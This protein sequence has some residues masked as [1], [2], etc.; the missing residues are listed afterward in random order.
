MAD[1][2]VRRTSSSVTDQ[3][4]GDLVSVAARDISQL[5]RY[6]LD[7][8]KLEL[9]ADAKRLGIGG[10]AAG[11]R[12]LRSLPGPDAALLRLRLRAGNARH[13]GVG[14]VPDR[15]RHLRADHRNC[16]ADRPAHG[17]QAG[18]DEQD[19][20]QP[21]GRDVAAAPRQVRYRR[22]RPRPEPTSHGCPR[23]RCH[24]SQR[25]LVAPVGQRQRH[26]IP[27]RGERRR[28]AGAA[29]ARVP[30]VLVDL[31]AAARLAEPGRIPR[32]RARPARLRRQRQAAPWL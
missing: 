25:T 14:R 3:S 4:I 18:R 1:P 5:V 31:A 17:A 32:G 27:R 6:E 21:G 11:R 12:P 16:S 29:A 9:K 30:R 22:P 8:A 23:Q 24:L 10:G 2:A 15:G 20:A 26:A 13:L 19:Q 28:A 7:L